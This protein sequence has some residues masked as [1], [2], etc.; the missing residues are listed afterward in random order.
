MFTW[1]SWTGSRE[2]SAISSGLN[3]L[4][5]YSHL[6][7]AGKSPL[8]AS[9]ISTFTASV[10]MS[11]ALW[12]LAC[13]VSS[14]ILVWQRDLINLQSSWLDVTAVSMLTV[15]FPAPP[16][17]GTPSRPFA[18]LTASTCKG[19]SATSIATCSLRNPVYPSF[20]NP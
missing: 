2:E 14:A 5:S 15:S 7:T 11:S 18:F 9:F 13:T 4:L 20:C 19:S 10:R 16:N 3:Y 12:S 6:L 8:C 17:C 1:S